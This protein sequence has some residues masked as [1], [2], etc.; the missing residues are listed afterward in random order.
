[1]MRAF[2]CAFLVAGA[3]GASACS[4]STTSPSS[5]S[6]TPTVTTEYFTGTLAPGTSQF[7]SFGVTNAGTVSVTLVSTQTARIGGTVGARLDV[8]VGVPSGF[9]CAVNASSVITPGLTAQVSTQGTASAI[10]C[11][12]IADAGTLAGDT[13]FVVRVSHT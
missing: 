8:G 2:L 12:N 3:L 6:S 7:Y 9:G 4:D 11:V 13:L 5:T 10:Y 1:M